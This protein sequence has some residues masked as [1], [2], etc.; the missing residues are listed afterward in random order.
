K[1][2]PDATTVV[3]VPGRVVQRVER[4]KS[5]Q[6]EKRQAIA[7]KMGFDAYGTT[8]DMPDPVAHAINCMLDHM[9]A[10]DSKMEEMCGA[11][12]TLGAEVD[13]DKM[14]HLSA[15]EIV[16]GEDEL[17]HERLDTGS[18]VGSSEKPDKK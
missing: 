1:S 5:E 9:H 12:K 2:V 17:E 7:D 6:S 11:I 3:G 14:P 16:S 10:M 8:P 15:C 18:A 13:I 4:E